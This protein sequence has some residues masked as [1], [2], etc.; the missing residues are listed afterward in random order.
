MTLSYKSAMISFN[1]KII[2]FQLPYIYGLQK[3]NLW[4]NT[5]ENYLNLLLEKN[6]E[7]CFLRLSW[8]QF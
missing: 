4:N 5:K 2:S 3:S 6:S 1:I 7:S 8:L